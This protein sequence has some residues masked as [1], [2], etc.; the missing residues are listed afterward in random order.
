M[1]NNFI[2]IPFYCLFILFLS[3]CTNFLS[4][5][6]TPYI[7]RSLLV[8]NPKI[9][10]CLV[11]GGKDTLSVSAAE[12][13]ND[14]YVI[15]TIEVG[16]TVVFAVAFGARSNQL[17]SASVLSSDTNSLKIDC[18]VNDTL[19]KMLI[20]P[21]DLNKGQMYFT[22]GWSLIG[23]P[24]YYYARKAGLVTIT[25]KVE[26]DSKYSPATVYLRQPIK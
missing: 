17:V 25:L 22:S 19:S 10:N 23:F 13:G 14:T 6:E 15:D 16:D 20:S 21:T 3:G 4:T 9:E 11:V 5:D 2:S 24:V 26:S 18:Q 1:K 8:R 12:S 7:S